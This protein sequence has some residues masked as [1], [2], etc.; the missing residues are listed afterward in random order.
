MALLRNIGWNKFR[1]KADRNRLQVHPLTLSFRDSELNRAY[2]DY[3][4]IRSASFV[5]ISLVLA[6]GLYIFFAW[7]DPLMTPLV[8]TELMINRIVSCIIF[9]GVI[10]LSYTSW[11]IK[12]LQFLMSMTIIFAG[13]GINAM[14]LV[15]ES[16][17]GYHY[18]AGLILAI[19]FAH[20]LLRMRFIYASLTTWFVVA[21]YLSAG[22]FLGIT[23]YNIYMNNMFFLVSA[24]IMGMFAS[25]WL[26]YY[27]KAVFW[28]ERVLKE[29]NEELE[30]EYQRK[31]SELEA[32]RTMQ[33]NMLPQRSPFLTDYQFS[34]SMK[35]ASEVGG[36]YYDFQVAEDNQLTFGIG[37]ATGHGLQA[38]VMVTAIKLLFSEHAVNSDLVDFLKQASRSISL[39]GFRKYYMAFAIGRL[40]EH[41]LELAGAGMPPALIYR[42][43]TETVEKIPLKGLP[44]GSRTIFPY[45]KVKTAIHP[46]DVVLFMTDGLPELFNSKGD[47]VGYNRVEQLFS[48]V[49]KEDTDSI[50]RHLQAKSE[51][52]LNGHPQNDDI[53]FFILKRKQRISSPLVKKPSPGNGTAEIFGQNNEQEIFSVDSVY[54]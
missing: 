4:A 8:V 26:E 18:Y 43:Q 2:E 6:I 47:M 9:V 28:N 36:D 31:S 44:L 49:A 32:A 41:T 15:S 21:T 42:T 48:A 37:D 5:R 10:Y 13:L 16:A 35:A 45:K 12:H 3:A 22:A 34:F 24:N 23:P 27:M 38:S 50:I 53:T 39:M 51:D 17:G 40:G 19:M 46:G 33:L 29:K 52:W 30:L 11:G 7:L 1:K 25:Y 20:G 54:H 14:I